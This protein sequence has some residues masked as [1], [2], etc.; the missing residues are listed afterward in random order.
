MLASFTVNVTSNTVCREGDVRLVD[1]TVDN[2][3]RVEICIKDS[4]E[5]VC[6]HLF[7]APDA[8]VVCRQL[9]HSTYS[10]GHLLSKV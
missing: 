1:G 10:M 2:E 8:E 4:W 6:D 9:G 5:R 3:G 7:D